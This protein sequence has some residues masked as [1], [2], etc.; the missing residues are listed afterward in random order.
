MTDGRKMWS[1]AEI[2]TLISLYEENPILWDVRSVNY[3][4]RNKK[5]DTLK[6]IATK[7]NT[8]S[9]EISRKLH[10]LRS[11]FM[12]EVKKLKIKKSGSGTDEI[13]IST[14]LYFSALKFIQCSVDN[15]DT[16]DNLVSIL[17]F[18]IYLQQ[19]IYIYIAIHFTS[20]RRKIFF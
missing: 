5:Q 1:D 6:L 9:N 7:L 13:F 20:R 2:K 11:Q 3:Q 8:D 17:L 16:T 14:W 19:I 10:N 12:Q 18:N 15:S 4:N